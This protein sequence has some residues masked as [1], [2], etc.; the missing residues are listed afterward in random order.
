MCGVV[1]KQMSHCLVI[2]TSDAW[3]WLCG[4]WDVLISTRY[5]LNY[6]LHF[7]L[8][9]EHKEC[10]IHCNHCSL[11]LTTC[12]LRKCPKWI[13]TTVYSRIPNWKARLCRILCDFCMPMLNSVYCNKQYIDAV[14]L[15]WV[16]LLYIYLYML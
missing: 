6:A 1:T 9:L 16:T 4:V 10:D 3:D 13:H 14:V 11:L 15:H 8:D 12:L 7:I 2:V 5:F